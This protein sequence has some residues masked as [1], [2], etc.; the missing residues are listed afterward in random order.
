MALRVGWGR[1]TWKAP[2]RKSIPTRRGR[3]GDARVLQATSPS[4]G[5]RQPLHAGKLPARYEGVSW[6][7]RALSQLA[8]LRSTIRS[9]SSRGVGD[10]SENRSRWR[11]SWHINK[12]A[13][14]CSRR[15]EYCPI[16]HLNGYKI[17]QPHAAARIQPPGAGATDARLWVAHAIL[18]R[19][20]R[21]RTRCI[22]PFPPRVSTPSTENPPRGA[23]KRAP[24]GGGPS[25]P[26]WP[27]NRDANRQGLGRAARSGADI[28]WK[29]P[30]G[31]A[32]GSPAPMSKKNPD[33][34]AVLENGCAAR[35]RKSCSMP[36]ASCLTGVERAGAKPER[37][38]MSRQPSCQRRHSQTRLAAAVC[39][40]LRVLASEQPGKSESRK[41][42]PARRFC[43]TYE[44]EP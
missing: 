18:R 14:S 26:R 16:L 31:A 20:D 41:H 32:P 7:T 1:F 8:A 6:A 29:A 43:A 22:R 38:A 10:G 3:R 23:R 28:A 27:M 24:R 19:E 9:S 15:R 34:L 37:A 39:R 44:D 21:T 25:E 36:P 5:D 42:A 30:G 17:K 13:L 11:T 2:T 12:F 33:Q 4:P 35:S 40:Q